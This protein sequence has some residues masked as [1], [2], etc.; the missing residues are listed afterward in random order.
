MMSMRLDARTPAAQRCSL[1]ASGLLNVHTARQPTDWFRRTPGASGLTTFLNWTGARRSGMRSR[2]RAAMLVGGWRGR[3]TPMRRPP[4]KNGSLCR[5]PTYPCLRAL[6]SRFGPRFL[7][8][9]AL[10]RLATQLQDAERRRD[11]T[12][13]AWTKIGAAF[14]AETKRAFEVDDGDLVVSEREA[15]LV[16]YCAP[17]R[18]APRAGAAAF[19]PHLVT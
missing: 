14:P 5:R 3:S 8:R 6:G 1:L 18:Q 15:I 16:R 7:A 10:L 2:G 17:L 9:A 19:T 12:L 13:P 11:P 4:V